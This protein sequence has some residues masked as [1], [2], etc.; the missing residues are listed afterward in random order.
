MKSRELNKKLLELIPE[1]KPLYEE[2]TSWQE[3]DD[4]GSH[5]VFSDVLFPYLIDN[6]KKNNEAT[7]HICF[8][9]IEEILNLKDD[10]AD[11]VIVISILEN[12]SYEEFEFD[13]MISYMQKNTKKLYEEVVNYE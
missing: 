2:E 13:K 11:E 3:G 12:L 6:L 4:T 7:I 5:V 9:A 8:K 10:Y 1:I